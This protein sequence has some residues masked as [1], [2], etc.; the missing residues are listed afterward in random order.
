MKAARLLGAT[1]TLSAMVF[2]MLA[3]TAP[4]EAGAKRTLRLGNSMEFQL[5][6]N[7]STGYTWQL[8]QENSEGLDLVEV[9]ALG[10][11]ESESD[12]V[13]APAPYVFRIT[14]IAAG[15]AHLVFDYIGPTGKRSRES[16]ETWVHCE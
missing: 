6:G 8:N 9:I 3:M 12:L 14:C 10:Y 16:H 15:F 11:G 2:T 5:E 4:S 13:G 7:P 1:L